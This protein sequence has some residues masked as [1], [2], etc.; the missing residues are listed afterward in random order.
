MGLPVPAG[1]TITTDACR[2]YM[3][4]GGSFPTVSRTRSTSMSRAR[5]EDRQ[6]LR[7]PRRPAAR[8]GPLGRGDLDAGDD[9]HD[10]QPRPQR[11]AVDGLAE[12]TGN[13]RFA[14]DSYRRLIQ[15]FGEVVDGID[16]APLRGRA[17][18][19][20][21]RARRGAG[22]R[23]LRRGSGRRW[24]RLT[25][26]STRR[27]TGGP[28]PQDARD[29]LGR[30]VH[31]VF[32]SWDTRRAPRSTGA[33]TTS[34]TTSAPRSTSSRWCSATRA[35]IG[36]RRRLHARSVDGRARP[37]RRVPRQRAGRGRRRRHP[38]ARAAREDGEGAAGGVRAA[39]RDDAPARGALPRHAGHR[40]HGRGRRLYLLQT[41]TAKRTAAAALKSAVDMVEEGLI[42]REE[43]VARIDPASSTSSCTR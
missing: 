19:A 20:E 5:G 29:Q 7:R 18:E 33:R 24:S 36:D 21:A 31:A 35:T 40:V 39:A 22:R 41:R 1:F 42:T 32:D 25:S 16:G 11:R 10:P 13:G 34:P 38:H 43:A 37:L 23:P 9:G 15:M 3:R 14:H 2:A 12:R 28:F 8:V 26:R 30:A 17:R 6:A 27:E 4:A